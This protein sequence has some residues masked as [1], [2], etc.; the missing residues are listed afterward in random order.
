LKSKVDIS[1][2]IFENVIPLTD[3]HMHSQYSPCSVDVNISANIEIANKRGLRI[4]AITDHGTCPEPS[5]FK[6]YMNEINSI[7]S[8]IIVL[9][10]M[11]VDVDLNGK[12]VVKREIL[13]KLKIVIAAL[14]RWPGLSGDMLYK[15]WRDT[16]I[17][18]AENREALIIAHPTDIGWRK[19]T[20][21]IEYC[22]EVLDVIKENDLV[23]ELNYHHSD[24][25][26]FFLSLCIERK[27]K[28]TPTSDA[29]KLDEIGHLEWHKSRIMKLGYRIKDVNWLKMKEILAI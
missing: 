21:P 4:I 13:K 25:L 20:P 6:K 16:L 14:H 12:L 29:H 28:L 1:S 17:T 7:D 23:V 27:V 11:E 3:L 22:M 5:W 8:E 2:R 24:P 9:P 26:D 18:I 19:I 15:W 10:G